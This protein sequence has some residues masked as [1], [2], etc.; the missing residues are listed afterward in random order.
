MNEILALSLQALQRDVAQLERVARNL[1]NVL[2]PGYKREVDGPPFADH[3]AQAWL[4]QTRRAQDG[5]GASPAAARIP[6]PGQVLHDPGPGT[7]RITGQ[8]LDL[9]ALDGGWFEVQGPQGTA[10]TRQGS[11]RLDAQSRLVTAQGHPVMGEG[12]E[13]RLPHAH[14]FIDARGRVFDGPPDA[15]TA[16]LAQLKLVRFERPRLQ[17][18]ADGL[19]A[20]AGEPVAEAAQGAPVVRQGAL[21]NANVDTL[22][23]MT[24][25]MRAM[26]HAEAVQRATLGYDE[27]VG[28]A[29]RRLADPS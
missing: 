8:P 9:A 2:T 24:R 15:H 6:E 21:E 11:F 10:Y 28:S 29:I 18:Q 12:G 14:P 19:Y 4:A 13:I 5:A 26:R 3:L 23:E 20:I 25:L 16:P 7:L 1:A 22:E 27:L 17:A